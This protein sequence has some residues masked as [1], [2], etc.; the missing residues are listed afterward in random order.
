MTLKQ[1]FIKD[2]GRDGYRKLSPRLKAFIKKI[3]ALPPIPARVVARI[4]DRTA[5]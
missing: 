4:H 2:L 3:D 1:G 5:A